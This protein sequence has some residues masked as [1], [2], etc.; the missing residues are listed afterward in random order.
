MMTT[1]LAINAVRL[2]IGLPAV[3]L[4]AEAL[5]GT[6]AALLAGSVL[7][8]EGAVLLG[9]VRSGAMVT[10]AG[11]ASVAVLVR[12]ERRRAGAWV[13]V[14]VVALLAQA[15]WT[16]RQL[17]VPVDMAQPR[18]AA[19]ALRDLL[20]EAMGEM[21]DGTTLMLDAEGA[22]QAE[23]LVRSGPF[24]EEMVAVRRAA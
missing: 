4:A 13:A 12:L 3:W 8:P 5:C 1:D 14:L 20:P 7:G 9:M 18:D 11:A 17:T 16:V 2:G 24:E 21:A 15:G 6:D 22:V 10:A 23:M 19:L